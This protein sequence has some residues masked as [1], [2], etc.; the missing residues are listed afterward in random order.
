M[1]TAQERIDWSQL[2]YPGPTRVFTPAE[3]ARAGTDVPSR[4]LTV[5]V[6]INAAL[7]GFVLLQ[8]A[9]A[10]ATA[11]LTALIAGLG[12]AG[13]WGAKALWRQPTRRR[14]AK[15]SLVYGA[16]CGALVAGVEWRMGLDKAG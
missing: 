9:P 1:K 6:A 3:M 13:L 12:L 7:L 14:L 11:R 10:E 16:A 4:T 15:Y 5:M 2:W 8:L